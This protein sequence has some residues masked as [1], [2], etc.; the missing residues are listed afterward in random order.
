MQFFS[1]FLTTHYIAP[2]TGSEYSKFQNRL[3]HSEG[4][5]RD[6]TACMFWCNN[7]FGSCIFKPIQLMDPVWLPVHPPAKLVSPQKASLRQA[8]YWRRQAS[9]GGAFW[10]PVSRGRDL[11]QDMGR[12]GRQCHTDRSLQSSKNNLKP[13]EK[14]DPEVNK[15]DKDKEL[16]SR[17]LRPIAFF[18]W[19]VQ[20]CSK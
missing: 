8:G 1:N 10:T 20:Q 15:R 2:L 5:W 12:S 14:C 18:I 9:P 11:V 6:S 13:P 17:H 4:C 19:F 3:P 7:K 16:K